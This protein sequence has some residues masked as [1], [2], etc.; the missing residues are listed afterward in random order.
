MLKME[1]TEQDFIDLMTTEGVYPG[2]FTQE[3]FILLYEHYYYSQDDRLKDRLTLKLEK[4]RRMLGRKP[5]SITKDLILSNWDEYENRQE[6]EKVHIKLLDKY[7][8]ECFT[9]VL[10]DKF[11]GVVVVQRL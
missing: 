6:A 7:S 4:S 8:L 10:T 1:I 11:T 2:R 3:G 9:T 5:I